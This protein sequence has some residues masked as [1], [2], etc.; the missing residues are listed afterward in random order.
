MQ[1]AKTG[2]KFYLHPL[3]QLTNLLQYHNQLAG[4]LAIRLLGIIYFISLILKMRAIDV[5]AST[6]VCVQF[7]PLACVN[8]KVVKIR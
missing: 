2:E 4:T 8:V 1:I 5:W 7:Y 6:T 3:R